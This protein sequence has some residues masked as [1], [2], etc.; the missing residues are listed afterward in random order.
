M[1]ITPHAIT[2]AVIGAEI[3]NPYLVV[4]LALAS[5]FVLDMLPHYDIGTAHYDEKKVKF[6]W[7]DWTLLIGDGVLAVVLIWIAFNGSHGNWNILIGAVAG[8]FPDIL[9][10]F[11]RV[12]FTGG[13]LTFNFEKKI[14]IITQLHAFH[15]RIHFKLKPKYWYWGVLTQVLVIVGGMVLLK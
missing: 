6:N 9:D 7:K 12:S 5:H 8:I 2:G 3:S 13:K 4:L 11:L 14:P 1:L 10:D 15:E